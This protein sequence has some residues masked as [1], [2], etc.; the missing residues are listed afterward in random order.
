M[1]EG[2]IVDA[3]S[4]LRRPQCQLRLAPRRL[5]RA[6]PQL[7]LTWPSMLSALW[8]P[9]MTELSLPLRTLMLIQ[10]TMTGRIRR[11]PP[12]APIASLSK[13]PFDAALA[14]QLDT[15]RWCLLWALVSQGD[16][17]RRHLSDARAITVGIKH[18]SPRATSLHNALPIHCRTMTGAL[19]VSRS[20]AAGR[21]VVTRLRYPWQPRPLQCRRSQ[22]NRW[23]LPRRRRW[24][25]LLQQ[26]RRPLRNARR[27]VPQ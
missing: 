5:H 1:F 26:T 20:P 6:R 27:C 19:R 13:R 15:V 25:R 11:C 21:S 17:M 7:T 12:A 3:V 18:V 9:C 23:R 22:S 2:Q 14:M 16:V 10:L 4:W 24:L 8:V